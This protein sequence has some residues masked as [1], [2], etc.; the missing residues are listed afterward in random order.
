MRVGGAFR[1]F[2]HTWFGCPASCLAP[3]SHW[4]A[5]HSKLSKLEGHAPMACNQCGAIH[6]VP[7]AEWLVMQESAVVLR[8]AEIAVE[9]ALGRLGA[10]GVPK[11]ATP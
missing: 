6:N 4:D 8:F 3:L 5:N 1:S 10:G 9:K 2:I 7:T 11:Q